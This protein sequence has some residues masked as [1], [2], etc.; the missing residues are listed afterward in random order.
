MQRNKYGMTP[1]QEKFAQQVCKLNDDGAA[2]RASFDAGNMK[3]IT[4]AARSWELRQN[5]KIAARIA[6][7]QKEAADRAGVE[8]TDVIRETARIAF[9]DIRKLFNEHGGLIPV[10]ELPD[11]VAAAIAS[12]EVFEEFEGR[13]EDRKLVGHLKKIK[14]WDKNSALEKFFKNKGLFNEDNKHQVEHTGAVQVEV[15]PATDYRVIRERIA[16]LR[17]VAG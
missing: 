10:H 4:V 2:Y 11:N 17:V 14:M 7:L 3:Q 15:R 1:K 12:I 13:G 16:K 6:L 9:S 5:P 8:A